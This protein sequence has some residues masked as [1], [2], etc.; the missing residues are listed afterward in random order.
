METKKPKNK[1]EVKKCK[2]CA[3]ENKN[4]G[5][6]IIYDS[7]RNETRVRIRPNKSKRNELCETEKIKSYC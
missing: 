5:N 2:D 4:E 3:F 1:K 6:G 7:E